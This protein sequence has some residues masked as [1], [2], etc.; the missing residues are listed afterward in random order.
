MM[1]LSTTRCVL[2][3]LATLASRP[4]PGTPSTR[5]AKTGR[6]EREEKKGMGPKKCMCHLGGNC[7]IKGAA[8][9]SPSS[10]SAF[11]PP[12][13]MHRL[14]NNADLRPVEFSHISS[15]RSPPSKCYQCRGMKVRNACEFAFSI[16]P[17]VT[18]GLLLN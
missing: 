6:P 7:D 11:E 14:V 18:R 5:R 1:R 15:V 2:S 16:L 10:R 9:F 12:E 17:L 4:Q 13:P 8:Y 3:A